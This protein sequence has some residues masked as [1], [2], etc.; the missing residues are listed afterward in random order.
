MN[1]ET[2]DVNRRNLLQSTAV[3]ALGQMALNTT[4]ATAAHEPTPGKPGDF[5]FLAGN[6]KISHRRLKTPGAN[7]W[8]I[9]EGTRPADERRLHLATLGCGR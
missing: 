4:A 9:F 2:A 5:N 8:D 3:L 6:W 7:D 1:D